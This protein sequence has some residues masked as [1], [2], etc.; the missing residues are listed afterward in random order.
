MFA[1][2]AC[3]FFVQKGSTQTNTETAGQKF[4][5]IKVLNEMPADQLGRVMNMFAAS[6]GVNCNFCHVASDT[7]FDKDGKKEKATAREMI[8]MTFE[9]NKNNFNN[10]PQVACNT[11]HGG[12]E[13]PISAPNLNPAAA[14]ERPKQPDV[15]PTIDEI[16][17]KYTSAIGGKAALAKVGSRYIKASRVERDGKTSESEEIWQK[18]TKL[19]VETQYAKYLISEGF[20]GTAAWKHDSY[21]EIKLRPD[22]TERIKRQAQTFANLDL[23]TVYARMDFRFVDRIDD[24]EVYL[25]LATTPDNNRERL[26]FDTQTGLLVRR[27][28]SSQT[29][30]GPFIFQID[31]SDYT[32]FGGV[33]LPATIRFAVPNTVF[34][35]KILEVKNNVTVDDA[36]F[37]MPAAKN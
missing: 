16:L 18:G 20:N 33:K 36:K 29:I 19:R 1:L 14:K 13:Q 5:N 17:D 28:G 12:H 2:F 30:F 10:R 8:K 15:K 23:K 37:D 27:T 21:G 6:L 7:D 32:A 22:E 3:A 9:I 11:C 24:R 35:R 4:K 25:V 34:T 26:Y 31:Y